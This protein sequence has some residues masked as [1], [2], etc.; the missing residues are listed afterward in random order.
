M[1]L[2][3]DCFTWLFISVCVCELFCCV[4][5]MQFRSIDFLEFLPFKYIK[6]FFLVVS[7][8][9]II[10]NVTFFCFVFFFLSLTPPLPQ[11]LNTLI[12]CALCI[13]FPSFAIAIFPLLL[14]CFVFRNL[15]FL[16][17]SNNAAVTKIFDFRIRN[18]TWH[19]IRSFCF[20]LWVTIF[21]LSRKNI[22]FFYQFHRKCKGTCRERFPM[23]CP[24]FFLFV[25]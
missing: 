5:F 21:V 16:F 23:S 22:V 6:L 2:H 18:K 4:H 25:F 24:V 17:N 14:V 7:L 19:W 20:P 1:H 13:S 12:V 10:L 11:F 15:T 9:L 8:G 3:S